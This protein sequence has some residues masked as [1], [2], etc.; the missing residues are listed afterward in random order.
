MS[1]RKQTCG[2]RR[3]NGAG[4]GG[5]AK[6]ASASRIAPGDPDGIQAMSND[7]DVKARAARRSEIM[8][9]HLFRLA[10]HAQREE[11]QIAAAVA[12]L[13]RTEGKPVALNI[14]HNVSDPAQL[15][16]DELSAIAA[17]GRR[18]APAEAPADAPEP[19]D[20]VH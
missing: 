7:E 8:R 17:R 6:G 9:D 16:D 1:G 19:G 3:G 14:N 13:D 4:W 5:P 2:T 15:S 11:T 20:V 10:Q 12:Y 18:E